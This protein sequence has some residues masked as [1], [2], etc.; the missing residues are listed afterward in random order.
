MNLVIPLS[1]PLLH[2]GQT[3]V[4]PMS[5]AVLLHTLRKLQRT[6]R[7]P[8]IHKTMTTSL[9]LPGRAPSTDPNPSSRLSAIFPSD[10]SPPQLN[11]SRLA[12]DDVV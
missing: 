4:S 6:K 11:K 2:W 1:I 9:S 3:A 12:C 7:N 8:T 5:V 10:D